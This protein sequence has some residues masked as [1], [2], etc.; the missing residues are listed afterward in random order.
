MF[1][2]VMVAKYAVNLTIAATVTSAATTIITNNTEKTEDDNIV[3]IPAA[4]VGY[5]VASKL[6]ARSDAMVDKTA[7]A[8]TKFKN[9]KDTTE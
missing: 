3:K 9:R 7:A 5:V 1:T 6:R 8:I 2:P 4:V